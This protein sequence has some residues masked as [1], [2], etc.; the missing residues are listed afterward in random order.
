[1]TVE[2]QGLPQTTTL[3]RFAITNSSFQQLAYSFPMHIFSTL[4][5]HNRKVFCFLGV[6]KNGIGNE[7]VNCHCRAL[8]ARCVLESW[9][10]SR[11]ILVTLG[12]ISLESCSLT[13]QTASAEILRR[14]HSY[15]FFTFA[16]L[17]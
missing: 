10:T 16:I 6:K 17:I 4:L 13:S 9:I 2:S 7:W 5:K 11:K 15:F 14:K 8:H 12:S 1:M 3:E